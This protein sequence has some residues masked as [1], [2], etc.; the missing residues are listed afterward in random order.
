MRPLEIS[1]SPEGMSF[2]KAEEKSNANSM[3]HIR[4]VNTKVP[5]VA[6]S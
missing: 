6:P 3:S 5:D 1:N 2:G 4:L